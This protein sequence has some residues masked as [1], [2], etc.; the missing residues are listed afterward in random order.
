[1]LISYMIREGMHGAVQEV[2][3]YEADGTSVKRL[4]LSSNDPAMITSRSISSRS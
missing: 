3:T 2:R 4:G 1:M